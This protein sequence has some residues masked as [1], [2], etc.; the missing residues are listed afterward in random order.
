VKRDLRDDLEPRQDFVN[1]VMRRYQRYQVRF[2]G[3]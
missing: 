1:D 2:G 3:I